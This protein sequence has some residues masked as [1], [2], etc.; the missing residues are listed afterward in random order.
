MY[1][2]SRICTVWPQIFPRVMSSLYC[3]LFSSIYLSIPAVFCVAYCTESYCLPRY[4]WRASH[5]NRFRIS[6][7]FQSLVC[8]CA[9]VKI[10]TTTYICAC[11]WW[12]R[13]KAS[14]MPRPHLCIC[15][16]KLLTVFISYRMYITYNI[17]SRR[18]FFFLFVIERQL[19]NMSVS[20]K[21][22]CERPKLF[23]WNFMGIFLFF[24]WQKICH[25]FQ[26]V[27]ILLP[28]LAGDFKSLNFPASFSTL[29]AK[30]S[31]NIFLCT[32]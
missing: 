23:K 17:W 24:I 16:S 11:W 4:D 2:L 10:R 5:F 32:L 27:E 8:V 14:M 25:N 31:R 6:Y 3:F 18:T 20:R 1:I 15:T 19:P 9:C 12:N 22:I 30:K 26:I 28:V 13:T 7:N 21:K 29:T